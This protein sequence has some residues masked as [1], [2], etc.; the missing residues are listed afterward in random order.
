MKIEAMTLKHSH[1]L[2]LLKNAGILTAAL[3]LIGLASCAK[4]SNKINSPAE[5]V[6][7]VVVGPA[8]A[9]IGVGSFA[10]LTA[11]PED[12]SGN[13][14]SGRVVTWSSDNTA[15]ATVSG[16]GLVAGVAAGSATITATSEGKSG[17]AAITVT[18]PGSSVVLVGAGDIAECGGSEEET[19][20][21]LDNIPGTVFTEIGRAHV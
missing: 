9:T 11:T 5:P 19:A 21:L 1:R 20:K 6:A 4:S 3:V 15:A 16:S 14:L 13:P 2:G 10:S 17:T 18:A 8:S 12:A 7:S